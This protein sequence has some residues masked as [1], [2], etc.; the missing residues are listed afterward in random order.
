MIGHV[1][2][3]GHDIF[4]Q[5]FAT[6]AMTTDGHESLA[7]IDNVDAMA[8]EA[9]DAALEANFRAGAVII[10]DTTALKLKE[11]DRLARRA[12][13]YGYSVFLVDMQVG[14]GLSEI[15]QRNALRGK[16]S[17]EEARVELMFKE[18][19]DRNYPSSVTVIGADEMVAVQREARP[20]VQD[21]NGE[22][23]IVF[24]DIQSCSR[25]LS[26]A[27]AD[28]GGW[29]APNTQWVFAGDL[30]DRG[31]DAAGVFHK[32]W[33][34]RENVY[35]VEGNHEKNL[36]AVINNTAFPKKHKDARISRDQI[37]ETR[38]TTSDMLDLL[39]HARPMFRFEQA[40]QEFVVTHGG[41]DL[42]GGRDPQTIGVWECIYGTNGREYVYRGRSEYGLDTGVLGDED[43]PTQFHGHRNAGPPEWIPSPAERENRVFMLEAQ[44]EFGGHLRVAVVEDGAVTIC[45]YQE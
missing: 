13:K 43:S 32:V 28:L 30:F 21:F 22:R 27:V 19:L 38:A 15:L 39:S 34:M 24:G 41:V 23:V 10:W 3:L 12:S 31:P 4:R 14:V 18:G 36:R 44:V 17:L 40:G 8:R 16:D 7:L 6:P 33:P 26:S 35:L 20:G 25:A 11:V 29:D 45:Q 37:L 2:H 9:A 42:R 5:Y 1:A